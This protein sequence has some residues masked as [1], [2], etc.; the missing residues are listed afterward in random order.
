MTPAVGSRLGYRGAIAALL[1]GPGTECNFVSVIGC[2]AWRYGSILTENVRVPVHIAVDGP[3]FKREVPLK[4]RSLTS[5]RS[6][7]GVVRRIGTR[8]H[9]EFAY[10]A[11]TLAPRS[12]PT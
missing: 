11:P 10:V 2:A 9:P 1:F 5:V 8:A 4:S 3:L 12:R 6:V 7:V